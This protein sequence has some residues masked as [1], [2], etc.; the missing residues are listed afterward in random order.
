MILLVYGAKGQYVYVA[1][2]TTRLTSELLANKIE[3]SN[4]HEAEDSGSTKMGHGN[5]GDEKIYDMLIWCQ[6]ES[7]YYK[8]IIIE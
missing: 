3:T 8:F 2:S 4:E 5:A 1:S 6:S 7:V